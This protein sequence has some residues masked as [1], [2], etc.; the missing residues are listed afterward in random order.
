M[1]KARREAIHKERVFFRCTRARMGYPTHVA[2]GR[3]IGSGPVETACK[4][5]VKAADK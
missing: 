5:M 1:T 3:P 2:K 4:T